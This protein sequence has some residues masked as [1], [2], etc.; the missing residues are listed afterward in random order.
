MPGDGWRRLKLKEVGPKRGHTSTGL[1]SPSRPAVLRRLATAGKRVAVGCRSLAKPQRR[2]A[3]FCGLKPVHE[4]E[5]CFSIASRS[6][7]GLHSSVASAQV[8][9][10]R[11]CGSNVPGRGQP[12]GHKLWQRGCEK[13]GVFA[14]E[15]GRGHTGGGKK[16]AYALEKDV[17]A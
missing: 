17:F 1:H 12:C 15:T 16:R 7:T 13:K 3:Q 4:V 11:W 6:R 14:L 5:A 10:E 9:M 8:R 2:L